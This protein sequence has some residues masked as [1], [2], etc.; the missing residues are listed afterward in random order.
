MVTF[1]IAS[2]F[3]TSHPVYII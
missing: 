3:A 1:V 2:E